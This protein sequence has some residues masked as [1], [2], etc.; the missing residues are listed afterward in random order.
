MNKTGQSKVKYCIQ[1]EKHPI[2]TTLGLCSLME[3]QSLVDIAICCG[4]SILHAHKI[5]LAAS[6]SLFREELE[7][8]PGIEQVIIAGCDFAVVRSLIEFMYC[9]ETLI[10]EDLLKY[11]VAAARLFQMKSLENLSMEFPFAGEL[12]VLPK[13]QFLSKKP[14]Y[15]AYPFIANP[16]QA[17]ATKPSSF[18]TTYKPHK[19][20]RKFR[21][22]AE[23]QACVKEAQAS[24]LAIANLKKE[25][26]SAPQANTFVIEETCMETTVENFIPHHTNFSF[27]DVDLNAVLNGSEYSDPGKSNI[28][29]LTLQNGFQ[30]LTADKIKNILGNEA[31]S[32]VEI[33]FKTNDGNFVTVTDEVLQNL[34]KDGL[35]YQEFFT[36]LLLVTTQIQHCFT[37]ERWNKIENL[38]DYDDNE[39]KKVE[40]ISRSN[41]ARVIPKF[42]KK[43]Y[44]MVND[45]LKTK[46]RPLF[47]TP[48]IMGKCSCDLDFQPVD[49]GRFY[50]PRFIQTGSC[51]ADSC[52]RHYSCIE[53][54]YVVQVL[55]Y[56]DPKT[57]DET[58]SVTLP[59]LLRDSWISESVPVTVACDCVREFK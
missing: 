49:L 54:K 21:L 57:V 16:S 58:S 27:V 55:K 36:I 47:E 1:L 28:I 22:E 18:N 23:H 44:P 38:M 52:E 35:Q 29:Q 51:Q 59:K 43:M 4:S 7:R 25:I 46:S 48:T 31:N 3:H 42:F 32:N 40:D 11:L 9:G 20:K 30:G 34:Q 5:V 26:A 17:I 19:V 24:R 53:R 13:P 15:P 2:H 10:N 50:F 45:F 8:N 14:K 41:I 39:T 6:S 37:S 56:K 12:I 33:M